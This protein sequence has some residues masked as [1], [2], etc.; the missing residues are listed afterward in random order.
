MECVSAVELGPALALECMRVDQEELAQVFIR[1]PGVQPALAIHPVHIPVT[2]RR[3]VGVNPPGNSS[4]L[5]SPDL[6]HASATDDAD[7]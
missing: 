6:V 7:V 4:I 5:A 1:S 3:L 2:I